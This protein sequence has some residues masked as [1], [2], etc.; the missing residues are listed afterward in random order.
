MSLED[1]IK[2]FNQILDGELD[3]LP[4]GAFYMVGDINEVGEKADQLASEVEE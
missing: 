1:T 4:E 3:H 2:G